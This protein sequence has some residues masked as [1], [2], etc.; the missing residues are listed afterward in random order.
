MMKVAFGKI[1]VL[2]WLKLML[3]VML[4]FAL[5]SC[6][7]A[8]TS[9]TV[10]GNGKVRLV[11]A[12]SVNPKDRAS[13]QAAVRDFR[14]AHPEIEVD[15]MEVAGDIY[16]KMLIMMAARNAPDLMWMGQGFSG[17]VDRGV[18]LDVT[19]RVKR[20]LDTTIYAPQALEWYQHDGR[21]YGVAFGLDLRLICYNKAL[22]D[23]AKVSYPQNGW[24]YDQFLQ[25]AKALTIDRDGDGRIDQ[26]GF[27]GDLDLSLFNAKV[28]SEEGK[29]ALCNSPEMIDF[30]Q[31]NVDLSEI[32]KVSP[33]GQQTANEQLKD[34]VT[35]F[36]QGKTAMMTMATWNL[37]E[38]QDRCAEMRWDV[39]SNPAVR[40]NGHWGSS[41]AIVISADT[42]F[43]EQSWM[44]AKVFLHKDFQMGK[45]PVILPSNIEAQKELAGRLRGKAPSVESM[46]I[47]SR[48]LYRMPRVPRMREL[49]QFWLDATE[50]VWAL[51]LTPQQAMDRAFGQINRAMAM[52]R[53]NA[54]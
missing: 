40:Q 41:Q 18:F 22:F 15:V 6:D 54:I 46:I 21:Q 29:G 20:D 19:D 43:P 27:E 51:K 49:M 9:T 36:R 34:P 32:H 13:Y 52:H 16:Q 25:A 17:M 50:S 14:T 1:F 31:T 2:E 5:M 39:V 30:L 3:S 11:L 10:G 45:F 28:I 48:S 26:Y 37:P 35:T 42:R 8:P 33:R 53:E 12:V 7:R 47:A 24:T 23:E 38:L 4:A 44:L